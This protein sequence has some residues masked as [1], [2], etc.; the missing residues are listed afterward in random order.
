[1]GCAQQVL[2]YPGD[3]YGQSV[4]SLMHFEGTNASTTFVD[5]RGRSWS[6]TGNAQISTTSPLVGVSSLLLDGVGDYISTGNSS[7]FEYTNAGGFCIEMTI[8]V[9]AI[10]AVQFLATTRP[11]APTNDQG[12]FFAINAT[13]KIVFQAAN[14][15]P[16]AYMSATSTASVS[17]TTLTRIAASYDGTTLRLFKDGTLDTSTTTKT[18]TYQ[19]S[20]QPLILGFDPAGTGP[21]YF[22]GKIDEF[23]LTTGAFRYSASYTP[24]IYPLPNA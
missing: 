16:G 14:T 21:R 1:M 23:R 24:E 11:A 5:E 3:I 18:G 6:A 20:T 17:A 19:T 7:A 15:V 13:G 12:W 9:D 2:A 8:S 22:K 4:V 10:G